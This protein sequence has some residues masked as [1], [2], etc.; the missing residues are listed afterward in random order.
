MNDIIF[1]ISNDRNF[2][3]TFL[4]ID[5]SEKK[6]SENYE[7]LHIVNHL[8]EFYGSVWVSFETLM[9]MY[10]YYKRIDDIEL[11]EEIYP[12]FRQAFAIHNDLKERG[13]I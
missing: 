2:V 3:L 13:M 10:E 7:F 4:I 12:Y 9:Y 1:I 8:C 6:L 11:F 5:V